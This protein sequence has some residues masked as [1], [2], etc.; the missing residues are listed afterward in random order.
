MS[1]S[2]AKK[3]VSLYDVYGRPISAITALL[4]FDKA[5]NVL[6][7]DISKL[8]AGKYYL[9]IGNDFKSFIKY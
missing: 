2:G 4:E 9:K 1:F 6:E 3:P 7:I 5:Q 8:R